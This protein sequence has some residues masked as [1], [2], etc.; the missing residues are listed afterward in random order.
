MP[1]VTAPLLSLTAHGEFKQ[2]ITYSH[3]NGKNYVRF[4]RANRDAKSAGQ[5]AHRDIFSLGLSLWRSLSPTEKAYWSSMAKFL[6][7]TI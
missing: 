6:S 4:Q 7:V 5:L 1:K 3:R 2:R